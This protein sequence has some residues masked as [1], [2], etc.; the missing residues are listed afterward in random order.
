MSTD[1]KIPRIRDKSKS[2]AQKKKHQEKLKKKETKKVRKV[3]EK[4]LK[5]ELQVE[6]SL[7]ERSQ[8]HPV[9][10]EFAKK[11]QCEI[12]FFCD[13]FSTV[14]L[15]VEKPQ[16]TLSDEN[17]SERADE[18]DV[19]EAQSHKSEAP[20]STHSN[21]SSPNTHMASTYIGHDHES[22]VGKFELTRITYDEMKLLFYPRN[23][24]LLHSTGNDEEKSVR[25]EDE[26][27]FIREPPVISRISNKF[28]LLDRLHESN[29]SEL[30][31]GNGDLRNFE[32]L[33]E[34][35]VYRLSCDRQF[36][37]IYVPPTPMHFEPTEKMINEKKFLKIFVNHLNFEQ[38]KLFTSE[39]YAAKLV[40]KLFKEY[41]RRCTFDIV[42]T[43]RNKL[44]NLRE[45]KAESF[46][47][48]PPK[49]TLK[50]EEI[51]LNQQIKSVRTKLHAEAQYDHKI[52]TSLLENW[53]LLKS[54]RSQQSFAITSL[55]LKIQKLE[56]DASTKQSERQQQYDAELNEMVGEEFEKYYAAKQRYKEMLKNSN[57]PDKIADEQEVVKKPKKPDID[58]IVA[59]LNEIYDK[60][61]SDELDLNVI[62]SSDDNHAKARDKVKKFN[63]VSYRIELEVDGEIVGSTKQCRLDEDFSI[64]VRAAFI[65]KLTKHLPEKLKLIVSTR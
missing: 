58:K 23:E 19:E 33:V 27:L 5:E 9:D 46:P 11:K 61:P 14:P 20:R 51:L 7:K 21:E 44:S 48:K 45:L 13:P 62:L 2:K 50:N 17:E 25:S 35:K 16:R 53:K 54:I 4:Y 37:P 29:A 52:L 42:G 28:L 10:E 3:S 1:S 57:D 15:N 65:L 38:H 31:D 36:T 39:H 6:N 40:E 59:E 60:L 32:S 22:V 64:P 43:L 56:T 49:S 24:N 41:E 12:D 55:T 34:D 26:G 18:E 30:I 63:R 8:T 47:Q